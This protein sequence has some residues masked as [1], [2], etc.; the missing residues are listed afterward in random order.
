MFRLH[1]LF[2]LMKRSHR[3]WKTV[4]AAY[5]DA[6]FKVTE[7]ENNKEI[8]LTAAVKSNSG[9]HSDFSCVRPLVTHGGNW[10]QFSGITKGTLHNLMILSMFIE[11]KTAM[12]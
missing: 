4:K 12:M 11:L 6:E 9:E 1:L 8:I 3:Q 10:D 2:Y 5:S 7:S